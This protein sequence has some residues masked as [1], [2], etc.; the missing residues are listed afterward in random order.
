MS[1]L[2]AAALDTCEIRPLSSQE[3][4]QIVSGAIFGGIQAGGVCPKMAFELLSGVRDTLQGKTPAPE[5]EET[6][7]ANRAWSGTLGG[8]VGALSTSC[9]PED[10]QAALEWICENWAELMAVIGKLTASARA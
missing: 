10:M 3:I 9:R 4:C 2:P 7:D 1:E 6:S 5:T 8:I